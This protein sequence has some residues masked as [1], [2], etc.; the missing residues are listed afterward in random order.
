[1]SDQ[2]NCFSAVSQIADNL[3]KEFDLLRS[4]NGGGFVENQDLRL[5]V[6]HFQNLNSLPDGDIYL[7]NNLL[8]IHLQTVVFRKSADIPVCFFNI[9]LRKNAEEFFY[10]FHSHD[11]V[12][13]NGIVGHQLEMLMN[14]SD[15][16]FCRVIWR[17]NADL[18]SLDK[19][20]AF[21]WFVHSKEHTHQ[22]GFPGPV[23]T[24]K[25]V[26]L[27]FFNL[28]AYVVVGHNAGKSF[29]NMPHFDNIF[30]RHR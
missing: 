29:C 27:A 22:S 21:I 6:K 9:Y 7:F 24:Q 15:I 1:M 20:L 18:F 10:G 17:C 26:D 28:D 30:F 11:N 8:R 14:H 25:R 13:R 4:E 19:D 3:Q 23:F 2:N 16:Q 5:A 12:F